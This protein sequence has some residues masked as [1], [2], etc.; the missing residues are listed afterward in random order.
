[1]DN[2]IDAKIIESDSEHTVFEVNIQEAIAQAEKEQHG[3][4]VN[5]RVRFPPD[6]QIGEYIIPLL[7]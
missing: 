6:V 7:Y 5:V 1:M 2:Y 4:I 3:R